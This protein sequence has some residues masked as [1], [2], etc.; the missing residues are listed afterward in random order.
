M[1]RYSIIFCFIMMLAVASS[2]SALP[3][4]NDNYVYGNGGYTSPYAGAIVET[5]EGTVSGTTPVRG[6]TIVGTNYDIRQGSITEAAS[7]W[8]DEN[9]DPTVTAG[10]RDETKYLT[11]PKSTSTLPLYIDIMF[12]SAQ[13]YLGLWWGSMD[14][15]NKLEF[16]DVGGTVIAGQ[17][18][19][20]LSY[21]GGGGEQDSPATNMYRNFYGMP[22]FYGVRIT[23][24]NYAFEI[25]NLA[26]GHNVVPEPTT[27]LLLG[28]GLVGLAGLRKKF[29]K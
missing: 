10:K 22:D 8:Y 27:M 3:L 13:N 18:V 7:P 6:W 21:S 29:Q 25:D 12:G 23:S 1:K 19:T 20:G 16:L 24:T 26:V 17:T 9:P 28:L 15:Y 11:V 4:Y 2:A 5:F 14:N